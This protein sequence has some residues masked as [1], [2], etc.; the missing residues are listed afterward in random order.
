[1][2]TSADQVAQRVLEVVPV[3]MRAVRAEMRRQRAADLSIPQ[4]RALAFLNRNAGASL[5]DVAEHIGLTL[6][7]MS[8][9]IDN[10]VARKLVT[11]QMHAGDRRYVTLAL[12]ARGRATLEHAL[13]STQAYL[14]E[15]FAALPDAERAV[16]ARAMELMRPLF[17]TAREAQITRRG[18][19]DS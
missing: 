18:N 1:M 7:S 12:T 16:I 3:V 14:A 2:S 9:L 17:A 13:E 19:G 5:S 11:R 8:K 15:Q 4:F 10:L 6:P